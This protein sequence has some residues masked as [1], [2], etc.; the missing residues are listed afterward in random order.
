MGK[1]YQRSYKLTP[2][3]LRRDF[4]Y[5]EVHK[6]M[7]EVN[8]ISFNLKYLFICCKLGDR[9]TTTSVNPTGTEGTLGI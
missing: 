6:Y 1:G 4:C 8:I 5:L 3:I 2:I 7:K 9:Q